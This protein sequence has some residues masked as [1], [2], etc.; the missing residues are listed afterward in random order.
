MS[1]AIA[2]R[3]PTPKPVTVKEVCSICDG[4]WAEHPENPTVMDCL[5]IVKA[6]NVELSLKV[7]NPGCCHHNHI[8]WTYTYPQYYSHTY[9][10]NPPVQVTPTAPTWYSPNIS[11]GSVG[12][13]NNMFD[14]ATAKSIGALM[15]S[16]SA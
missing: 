6:K 15:S 3:V 9:T 2:K 5:E 11:S 4:D 12:I 10:V 14:E 8:Q 1:K 7:A 13:S 16:V